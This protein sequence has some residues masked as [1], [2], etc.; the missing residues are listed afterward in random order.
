M[1]FSSSHSWSSHNKCVRQAQ[2]T[3]NDWLIISHLTSFMA[4]W[5]SEP[6]SSTSP[7]DISAITDPTALLRLKLE[8][9]SVAFNEW[10]STVQTKTER[11]ILSNVPL[12]QERHTHRK[13]P[14]IVNEVAEGNTHYT[15]PLTIHTEKATTT[16]CPVE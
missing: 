15:A 9:T 10:K 14:T 8:H 4:E 2:L 5:R 16:N 11:N 13:C 7:C 12:G 3:V 1:L 6:M